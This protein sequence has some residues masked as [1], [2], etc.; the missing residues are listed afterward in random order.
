[1][2]HGVAASLIGMSIRSLL[3]SLMER[4]TDPIRVTK[5]LNRHVFNLFKGKSYFTAIYLVIDVKERTIEYLN[6]GHPPGVLIDNDGTIKELVDGSVP[7]GLMKKMICQKGKLSYENPTQIFLYTDG[8]LA[9]FGKNLKYCH[10]TLKSLY[11]VYKYEENPRTVEAIQQKVT[12]L[13]QVDDISLV[14]ICIYG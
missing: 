2:G 14:S 7:I 9:A 1:M 6:A 5:E 11:D 12:K 13:A 8:L 4:V 3:P 10:E